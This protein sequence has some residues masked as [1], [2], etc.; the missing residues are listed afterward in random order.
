MSSTM[1]DDLSKAMVKRVLNRHSID[2]CPWEREQFT[3]SKQM[4]Y[5]PHKVASGAA[6][7]LLPSG[8]VSAPS[9]SKTPILN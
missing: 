4:V 1:T 8:M 5:F 7:R 9:Y 3:R 2:I 6:H